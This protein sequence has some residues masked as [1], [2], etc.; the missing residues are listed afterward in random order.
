[1]QG[2]GIMQSLFGQLYEES[3]EEVLDIKSRE[4]K[5]IWSTDPLTGKRV[6]VGTACFA[7]DVAETKVVTSLDEMNRCER[8]RSG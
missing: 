6:E 2:D 1:M 7:D 4:S 5:N 3:L 8:N